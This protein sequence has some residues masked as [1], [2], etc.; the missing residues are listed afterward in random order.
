MSL[1]R[2]LATFFKG[3]LVP[4]RRLNGVRSLAEVLPEGLHHRKLFQERHVFEG[5]V[6]RHGQSIPQDRKDSNPLG[7]FLGSLRGGSWE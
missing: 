3:I 7:E 2:T 5:K 6:N 4:G 1:S